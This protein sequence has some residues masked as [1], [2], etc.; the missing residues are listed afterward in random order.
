MSEDKE[1][2][3][4][5][6]KR[7]EFLQKNQEKWKDLVVEHIITEYGENLYRE[8][9]QRKMDLVAR[10]STDWPEWG[11]GLDFFTAAVFPFMKNIFINH[12]L[13]LSDGIG[14]DKVFFEFY[15]CEDNEPKKV[16][17]KKKENGEL[18]N[19][20][21]LAIVSALEDYKNERIIQIENYKPE[22]V[23]LRDGLIGVSAFQTLL[24]GIMRNAV[25]H[26]QSTGNGKLFVKLLFI[27]DNAKVKD[28]LDF[29]RDEN[30]E[31]VKKIF[32]DSQ[33]YNY[34]IIVSFVENEKKNEKVLEDIREYL[35]DP[36]LDENSSIKYRY[37]GMKEIKL[38]AG[39]LS[40]E[41][42]E[43]I[44]EKLDEYIQVGLT[45]ACSPL[46][47]ENQLAYL[48]KL[49]KPKYLLVVGCGNEQEPSGMVKF[50]EDIGKIDD[51]AYEFL[52]YNKDNQQLSKKFNKDNNR[53]N[54]PDRVSNGEHIPE[55]SEEKPFPFRIVG[56]DCTELKK[57][58]QNGGFFSALN[59]V[60]DKWLERIVNL[61]KNS[62]RKFSGKVIIT[63]GEA[64]DNSNQNK[65]IEISG[66]DVIIAGNLD[67][68]GMQDT[69]ENNVFLLRHKKVHDIDSPYYYQYGTAKDPFFS[70]LLQ[71]LQGRNIENDPL[72]QLFLRKFVESALMKILI[73]DERIAQ[74]SV[75]KVS[76]EGV[77]LTEK[78]YH[79]GIFIVS[80]II[81]EKARTK[82]EIVFVKEEN[83]EQQEPLVSLEIDGNGN[84]KNIKISSRT[85]ETLDFQEI[86]I[87]FIHLTKLKDLIEKLGED[88]NDTKYMEEIIKKW[89]DRGNFPRQVIVHSGRGNLREERPS[90]APFLEFSTLLS[91]TINEPS[92]FYLT[93]I[94]M[95]L[96]NESQ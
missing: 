14:V 42:L 21:D 5:L 31:N 76:E 30:D 36:I 83:I 72:P 17:I 35:S 18:N 6:L 68:V 79:M 37:W 44:D 55:P 46:W 74:Y 3:L 75:G 61:K 73:I 48:I 13:N 67:N 24:M 96:V 93:Q 29:K 4:P 90:N 39:F 81:K 65:R 71:S 86:D 62:E 26:S 11:I 57:E 38:C 23:F 63:L 50:V 49:P 70:L 89:K 82:E 47:P 15:R 19:L 20:V 10:L 33:Q 12:F 7:L 28:I 22:I 78:L 85:S 43:E 2:K 41:R 64:L 53:G 95:N 66:T 59:K 54:H 34:L 51:P 91:H 80:K 45:R 88:K 32:Q 40:G 27:K 52:V 8:Y 25:K 92:K 69:T 58:L 77:F 94:A 84:I 87:I 1:L 56:M 16:N 9:R 60:Y